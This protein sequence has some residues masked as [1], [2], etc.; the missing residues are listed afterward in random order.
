MIDAPNILVIVLDTARRDYFGPDGSGVGT[1]AFDE[2]ARRGIASANAISTSPWTVPSHAS[3]FSGLL[4]FEHGITGTAAQRSDGGLASF[5]PLIERLAG[6]WLPEIFRNAGYRTIGVSANPWLTAAMGFDFGF[7]TFVPIGMAQVAPR[8]SRGRKRPRDLVPTVIRRGLKRSLRYLRDA[9][10]GRDFGAATALDS[11]PRML[12]KTKRPFFCF[13]N[14]ME[15]H[16]P[17]LPPSEFNPLGGFRRY[18]GPH[19]IHRYMDDEAVLA[20][21]LGIT[22]VP[23]RALDTLRALYSGEIAYADDFLGKLLGRLDTLADETLIAVTSDHGENLGEDHLLGHQ[24]SLDDRLL[25]V[26]L[27]IAGPSAKVDRFRSSLFG[28]AT[29]PAALADAAGIADHPWAGD[30]G[31][32][33]ISH[34]EGGWDQVRRARTARLHLTEEQAAR[35]REP[36]ERATDGSTTVLRSSRGETVAGPAGGADR[37]RAAL[38]KVVRLPAAS[39]SLAPDLEREIEA[40]LQ[41]LGYL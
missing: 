26:P 28:M 3:L 22:D 29:F 5:R 16:S 35:L 6:R 33:A 24:L 19:V 21:N 17:Y 27:A 30:F 13:L 37:L 40:R 20:Y 38:E 11:L 4:P 31:D 2:I 1:P 39:G 8:G 32:I 23:P 10:R 7:E 12:Q 9:S 41:D 25:S 14:V 36:L 15:P 34:Y 18:M